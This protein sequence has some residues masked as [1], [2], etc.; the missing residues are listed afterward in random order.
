[1]ERNRTIQLEFYI[2]NR[3]WYWN[4]FVQMSSLIYSEGLLLS[5]YNIIQIPTNFMQLVQRY[6]KFWKKIKC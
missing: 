5:I 3:I 1:M 2:Y 6:D 4:D